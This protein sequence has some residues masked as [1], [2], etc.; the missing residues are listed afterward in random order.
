MTLQDKLDA[1]RIQ[2]EAKRPP[3]ISAAMHQ[4]TAELAASG[5]AD[6]A[7][8]EGDHAPSFELPGPD[9]KLVSSAGLLGSGPFTRLRVA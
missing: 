1:H 9:G 3:H 8:K 7:L 5:Q 4:A 2:S 6:R